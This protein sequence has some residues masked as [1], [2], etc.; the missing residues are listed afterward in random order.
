MIYF[1]NLVIMESHVPNE[2][3]TIPTYSSFFE[4]AT[5]MI[6]KDGMRTTRP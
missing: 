5:P 3:K 6:K 1:T 2:Y 4:C